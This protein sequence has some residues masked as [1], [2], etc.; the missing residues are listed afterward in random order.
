MENIYFLVGK[1]MMSPRREGN[2]KNF[3]SA[4]AGDCFFSSGKIP[5]GMNSAVAGMMTGAGMP[6]RTRRRTYG[7]GLHPPCESPEENKTGQLPAGQVR[8]PG[9]AGC[10]NYGC[11]NIL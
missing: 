8:K 5:G 3:Q 6:G 11:R 1:L 4:L 2:Q 9:W 7:P 10:P